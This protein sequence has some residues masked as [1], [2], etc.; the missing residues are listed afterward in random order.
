MMLAGFGHSERA[1]RFTGV[2]SVEPALWNACVEAAVLHMQD[3]VTESAII[4]R[5]RDIGRDVVESLLR[6]GVVLRCVN[7]AFAI[8]TLHSTR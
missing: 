2:G 3:Q 6:Y 4:R 8:N 7:D 1:A 5:R